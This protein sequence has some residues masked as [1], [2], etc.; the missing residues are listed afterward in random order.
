MI[1]FNKNKKVFLLGTFLFFLKYPDN[2]YKALIHN[3]KDFR[4]PLSLKGEH[5]LNE[6]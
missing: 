3:G 2:S 6:A 5:Q 1:E 4:S